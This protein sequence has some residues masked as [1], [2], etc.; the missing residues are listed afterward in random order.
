M[1]TL[2]KQMK[3]ACDT[4]CNILITGDTGTGK[5]VLARKIH[6]NS[7]RK[8]NP[9]I[10]V[11]LATLHEGTLESELFGYEK[12]AFTGAERRRVGR[13]EM[14]HGGTVFLDEIG[15]LSG[16]MQARLLEVLQSRTIIPIGSNREIKL[17]VRVIAATHRD[18]AKAVKMGQFRED[19]F[20]RL[21]VVSIHLKS[22]RERSDEFEVLLKNCLRDVSQDVGC[23]LSNMTSEVQELFRSYSWPGNLRE[24]R[25]V[26]EYSIRAAEGSVIKIEDLPTWFTT[27]SKQQIIGKSPHSRILGVTEVPLTLDFRATLENF[28]KEYLQFALSRN[29]GRICRTAHEIG[30]S[31]T[32]LIR[33]IRAYG[34]MA[35]SRNAILK[36]NEIILKK[37]LRREAD[38]D[39]NKNLAADVE[40]KNES[41]GSLKIWNE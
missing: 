31:K 3:I 5:S 8:S 1:K 27:E 36:K 26:L 28:Q 7:S 12:G 15:E 20:H 24:L 6:E 33:R 23:N 10:L 29:G 30:L 2:D 34:L 32:T 4:D 17:N 25:N 13:L 9:F 37:T 35:N 16:K 40:N 39:I 21:R 22:L 18:L 14:A 41:S 38:L 11:N 19:L